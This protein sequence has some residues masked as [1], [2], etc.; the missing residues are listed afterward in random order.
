M[1]VPSAVALGCRLNGGGECIYNNE[2][3]FNIDM[4]DATAVNFEWYFLTIMV[5]LWVG[6]NVY[7]FLRMVG[8][9]HR[10]Y[11]MFGPAL[12]ERHT[13]KTDYTSSSDTILAD[14]LKGAPEGKLREARSELE[15]FFGCRRFHGVGFGYDARHQAGVK[16]GCRASMIEG[17][18]GPEVL[19]SFTRTVEEN[20]LMAV[21]LNAGCGRRAS[22]ALMPALLKY[23]LNVERLQVCIRSYL[24][25]LL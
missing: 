3:Y 20:E 4:N 9:M 22:T 14:A 15:N 16:A 5:T 2:S 8:L 10:N 25:H 1:L 6:T 17:S 21:L 11:V 13:D 18:V 19:L 24:L 12:R 7:F 23:G